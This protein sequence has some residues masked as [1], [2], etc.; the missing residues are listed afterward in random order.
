MSISIIAAM[1]R[2]RVIGR[3]NGMPWRLPADL[4][5]FKE[6]TM[7]HTLIMGRKTFESL[8]KFLAG[9][10]IIVLTR[11]RCFEAEGIETAHTLEEAVSLA[12]DEAEI[13]I[14]GGAEIY[15]LALDADIADTMYLTLIEEDFE[16]DTWF[17]EYKESDWKLIS[18]EDREK[19]EKNPYDF[20]FLKYCRI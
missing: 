13:F 16:G 15:S 14:A 3:N 12:E 17:P 6:T 9:R 1:S 11:D 7:G 19:D 20:S 5:F 10:R 18:R 2:N 8:Q 4:R